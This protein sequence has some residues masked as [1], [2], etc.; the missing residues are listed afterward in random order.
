M[1]KTDEKLLIDGKRL[2]GRKPSDIRDIEM[3]VGVIPNANGSSFVR[4]GKT[5]AIAAVYGPRPLF[6]RF[7]RQSDTGV[8]K[9]RYNMIPFSVDDRKRP[10]PSR[11]ETE[12]SKV[13]RLAF[14]GNLFLKN[15]PET[16]VDVYVEIIEADGSTRVTA[17]N[18][19]SLA[20]A[21]AGI[22]MRDLIVGLSGGKIEDTLVL[23]V[24]GIEDN[25]SEADVPMAILPT[26]KEVTLLQMDGRMKPE[27]LKDLVK[28]VMNASQQ[29]YEKQVEVLRKKYTE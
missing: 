19:A 24:N 7:L 14:E 5:A 10:G 20:L 27:E 9:V 6:P 15:Y 13:I 8:L 18:A 28:N 16:V 29:I 21:D 26:K 17:I 3:K 25:N 2:D 1:G 22:P 12:I 23:D 4:F 11:R